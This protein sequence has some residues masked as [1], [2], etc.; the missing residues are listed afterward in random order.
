MDFNQTPIADGLSFSFYWDVS[1][2]AA[3][4]AAFFFF[5]FFIYAT[6]VFMQLCQMEALWAAGVD[7]P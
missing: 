1:E 7:L 3:G 4:K 6:K 5:F 2:T